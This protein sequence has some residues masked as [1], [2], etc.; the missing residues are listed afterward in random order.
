MSKARAKGTAFETAFVNYLN[1]L[2]IQARRT[3]FSSAHGDVTTPEYPIV[4]EGKNCQTMTLAAWVDQAVR[5]ADRTRRIPIVFHKRR[6][7]G[8][9]EAYVT[10]P[11]WAMVR[12]LQLVD[13][14][15]TPDTRVDL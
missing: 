3:G 7:K 12:V 11:A 10:M 2:G 13:R 9:D 8:I 5:S 14:R 15:L 4:W 6:G 1:D